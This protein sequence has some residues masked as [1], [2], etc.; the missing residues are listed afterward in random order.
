MDLNFILKN[1]SWIQGLGSVAVVL[2][3]IIG[4]IITC[5]AGVVTVSLFLK[6]AKS[7]VDESWNALTRLSKGALSSVIIISSAGV[8]LISMGLI[9]LS[10]SSDEI[11]QKVNLDTQYSVQIINSNK[12]SL[13]K[14]GFTEVKELESSTVD[15]IEIEK[16][17]KGQKEK[18]E[19][20]GSPQQVVQF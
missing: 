12:L 5:V 9:E 4:V 2:I 16:Y 10:E 14:K 20:K 1:Y 7:E 18:Y 8:V 11:D 19:V 6:I 17:V 15:G 3:A 13:L